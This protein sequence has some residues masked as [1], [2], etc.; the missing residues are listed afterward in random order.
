MAALLLIASTGSFI[1]AIVIRH[2]RDAAVQARELAEANE[3]SAKRE[4]AR[5]ETAEQVATE[6]EQLARNEQ[7]RAEAAEKEAKQNEQLAK[8]NEKLANEN[9]ELA[10]DQAS[11]ATDALKAV[12]SEIDS[13]LRDAPRMRQVRNKVLQIALEKADQVIASEETASTLD[14]SRAAALLQKAFIYRQLNQPAKAYENQMLAHEILLRLAD[15]KPAGVDADKARGNLALSFDILGDLVFSRDPDTAQ[16]YYERADGI[17][18]DLF[19]NHESDFYALHAREGFLA[20]SLDKLARVAGNSAEARRLHEEALKLR[21]RSVE[22]APKHEFDQYLQYLATTHSSLGQLGQRTGDL[23]LAREHFEK[24][25][26]LRVKFVQKDELNMTQ[27]FLVAMTLRGLGDAE[28][29][30]GNPEVAEQH[31]QASLNHIRRLVE[32]DGGIDYQRYHSQALYRLGAAVLKTKDEAAAHSH[33]AESVAI[34]KTNFAAAIPESPSLK[35]ELMLSLARSGQHEE[36]ANYAE[37]IG[38]ALDPGKLFQAGCGFSLCISGVQHLKPKE[39]LT[40]EDTATQQRYADKAIDALSRA[41]DKG[42]KDLVAL[43]S[44]PDLEAVRVYPEFVHLT[45]RLKSGA[46]AGGQP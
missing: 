24:S 34:L 26:E 19:E 11:I 32:L 43:E 7:H 12:V 39:K 44:D 9:A 21:L 16:E 2:E 10:A 27:R 20:D 18:Q 28:L 14:R 23:G 41:I 33:F 22:T 35:T 25:L 30:A 1:A 42:Y 6:K 40:P 29:Y 17:R 36:A 13:V 45:E 15:S 5:A 31:Y 3:K 37:E 4:Q 38:V 8:D 46:A